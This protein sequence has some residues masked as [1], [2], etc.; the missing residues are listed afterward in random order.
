VLP[1]FNPPP[2]FTDGT[3]T[4]GELIEKTNRSLA[5][6]SLASNSLTIDGPE[7]PSLSGN[8]RWER[9]DNFRLETKKFS[10][11][12]GTPLA[13]GSNAD[14]FW[15]QS[16]YPTPTVYYAR[17][18]EFDNQLGGRHVLPVSPLWLREAFGIVELDPQ[19]QHE[20][21]TIRADGKLEVVS[22]IPLQRGAYRRKLTMAPATG[23]IEEI[24]LYDHTGKLVAMAK[25]SQHQYYSAINWSLPHQ[26]QIQLLPDVGDPITFKVDVAFYQTNDEAPPN[27]FTFPDTTGFKQVDLVRFNESMQHEAYGH[28]NS[29]RPQPAMTAP[30]STNPSFNNQSNFNQANPAMHYSSPPLEQQ[31]WQVQPVQPS[32]TPDLSAQKSSGITNPIYR[33]ASQPNTQSWQDN[34][35]R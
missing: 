29:D 26:I 12:F 24:T 33:T 5:V 2:V 11:A 28:L 1:E 30:A 15:L 7:F 13:A 22:Y 27:S 16:S 35:R 17:H 8:F 6:N 20:G 32:T 3:P 34:L 18:N 14:M 25:M 10:R 4:L 23:T 31:P 19:G 21:P 9:P